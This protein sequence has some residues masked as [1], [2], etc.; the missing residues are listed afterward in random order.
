VHSSVVHWRHDDGSQR[1]YFG[2]SDGLLHALD[3]R[4]GRELFAYLPS[5]LLPR[6]AALTQPGRAAPPLVDGPLS[7]A[8]LLEP[9]GKRTL[10]VGGLGAGGAGLF[11]LDPAQAAQGSEAQAARSVL[12][13][14][15]PLTPGFANLGETH[16]MP[17]IT[18]LSDAARTPAVVVGNGYFNSGNRQASLFV[19]HA[20]TGALIAELATGSGDA[21][22]PNGLSSPA[23]VDTDGDGL[24]DRAYAGD[25]WGQLWRFEL[26]AGSL[27]MSPPALLFQDPDGSAIT[28]APVVSPHPM[29]GQM[30]VFG[31]GRALTQTDLD[32]RRTH[33]VLGLWDGAPATHTAWLEQWFTELPPNA[34]G[35][36]WRHGSTLSPNWGS[37]SATRP[38]HKGWRLVLPAGERLVGEHPLLADGVYSFSSTN[39]SR[40]TDPGAAPGQNWLNQVAVM[41]GGAPPRAI[42]DTNADGAVDP[43]DQIEGHVVNSQY[44]GTGVVSQPVLADAGRLGQTYINHNPELTIAA[45]GPGTPLPS[46]GGIAGGHFDVDIHYKS[47]KT[48]ASRKHQH[49]Y[50]DKYNVVGVNFNNPS[51]SAFALSKAVAATAEFKVLVLNAYLNPASHL[52]TA[53]TA[54]VPVKD[55]QGQ[56]KASAASFIG[57]LPSF[58]RTSIE[59]FVWRLPTDAFSSRDWWQDGGPVRA[60]LMPTET[61]CVKPGPLAS[62]G[63]EGSLYNGALTLQLVKRDTPASALE[64]NA[65]NR[66]PRYGWRLKAGERDKWLLAE[67]TAFWHHPANGCHGSRGWIPDPAQDT[68]PTGKAGATPKG[69]GDPTGSLG[70]PVSLA[71]IRRADDGVHLNLLFDDGSTASVPADGTGL[72]LLYRDGTAAD[73]LS[74]LSPFLNADSRATPTGP[75]RAIPR[76]GRH[77]WREFTPPWTNTTP[78]ANTVSR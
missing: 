59:P 69:S 15:T 67:Y 14:I 8:D 30:V 31:T 41:T 2:A 3:V 29:G 55:F 54:F 20:L 10:L 51:D 17:R 28:T 76:S 21:G 33:H 64:S 44:L 9:Q 73:R 25:L 26:R 13:E 5:M 56:A 11:A 4:T 1:L 75:R 43:A 45:D 24:P 61:D 47:G 48:Y 66:D 63:P 19:V 36:R 72:R 49:E 22:R 40:K 42:W 6:L 38:G 77:N 57:S 27:G 53:N 23:L 62:P 70:G 60:G 18:R 37:A 68:S 71:G 32:D 46:S 58:T 52:S 12:W 7:M 65:A 39:P 74:E 16:A 78:A 50:D 35:Q 34:N